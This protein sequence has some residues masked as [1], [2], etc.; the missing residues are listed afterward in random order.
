MFGFELKKIMLP[1]MLACGVGVAVSS[2]ALASTIPIVESTD[3]SAER[4]E[5]TCGGLCEVLFTQFSAGPPVVDSV[6]STT[7]GR[8][9]AVDNSA[10]SEADWVNA[11]T[12]SSFSKDDAEDGKTELDELGVVVDKENFTFTTDAMFILFKIGFAPETTLVKNLSGGTLELTWKATGR[13]A[14]LSHYTEFG[15]V[16][17]PLPAGGLLLITALG[18]LGIAVRRR[19]KVA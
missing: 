3:T 15:A 6:F 7:E 2:E 10:Q 17:I 14:G 1:A 12:G 19:R 16:A 4:A 8:L 18:G 5:L 13:G 9:F 11:N